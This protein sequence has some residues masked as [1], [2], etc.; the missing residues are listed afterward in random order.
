MASLRVVVFPWQNLYEQ[1]FYV[2]VLNC[3]VNS[4]KNTTMPNQITADTF[5][6]PFDARDDAAGVLDLWATI[7]TR[8]Q[9]I[10]SSSSTAKRGDRSGGGV[11]RG[12]S[13][14]PRRVIKFVCLSE[15][16]RRAARAGIILSLTPA[17]VSVT[18]DCKR[19]ALS[20]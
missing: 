20:L 9:K 1:P 19:S 4:N 18:S 5:H 7:S 15:L 14:E 2:R 6:H 8:K 12:G 3:S 17:D 16:R 10:T 11:W 13:E